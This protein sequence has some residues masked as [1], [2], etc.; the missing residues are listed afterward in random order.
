MENKR[1]V[2]IFLITKD[3]KKILMVKR[4]KN[5]YKDCWN[6]I[7]GKICFMEKKEKNEKRKR[8]FG[9]KRI[10]ILRKTSL[11]FIVCA[12]YNIFIVLCYI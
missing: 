12:V 1:F 5:P 6:G 3:Y 10:E 9:K 7:G 11:W 8:L 4:N 2:V